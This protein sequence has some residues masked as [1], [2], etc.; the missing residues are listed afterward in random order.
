MIYKIWFIIFEKKN[1]EIFGEIT[2]SQNP[3]QFLYAACYE[4]LHKLINSF[5]L[6]SLAQCG[7]FRANFQFFLL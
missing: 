1:N 3:L 2:F 4:A 5:K 7:K 6:I